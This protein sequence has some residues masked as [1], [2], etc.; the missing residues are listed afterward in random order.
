MKNLLLI[1]LLLVGLS[2]CNQK[3]EIQQLAEQQEA[4]N[5][6]AD[7][8]SEQRMM[9]MQ[10]NIQEWEMEQTKNTASGK[11]TVEYEVWVKTHSIEN[12]IKK[13]LN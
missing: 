8:S 12:T 4:E 11:P 6:T 13:A 9:G 3:S 10:L 7:L 2:S 5:K 1:S